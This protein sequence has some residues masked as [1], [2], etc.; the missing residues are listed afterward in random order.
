[1]SAHHKVE[2]PDEQ[3][4]LGS[5]VSKLW[6][7][8]LLIGVVALGAGYFM[9]QGSD[10]TREQFF[11]SYLQNFSYF[12]SLAVGCLF[13]VLI[14][15][16]C[17]AGWS[18]SLR[19]MA[20][21]FSMTLIPLALLMLL[22]IPGIHDLY[23]WSHADHVEGDKILQGKA[24]WLNEGFFKFRLVFY[25][26][27]W[28]G[29]AWFFAR[30]SIRQDQSKD[31]KIT[32]RLEGLAAPAM[33]I[34]A[35]SV[36]MAAFDLL[37]SLYP[38]WYSTIW[39]VYFFA[40]SFLGAVSMMVL[41]FHF[42]QRTGVLQNVVTAEH[43]QDL[44]KLMFAFVVFW[45][46]IGF[47]QFMLIWYGNIPEETMWYKARMIGF[48]E[49]GWADVSALLLVGHFIFPFFFL[50]SRHLKRRGIT[51]IFGAAWLLVMHWIDMHWMVMPQLHPAGPSLGLM[52][53]LCFLGVGGIFLGFGLWQLGRQALIPVGDPRLHESLSFENA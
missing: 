3:L 30:G 1:M 45:A 17:R 51:L 40:G 24:P 15:R 48:G 52:D 33:F 39:G 16:L 41:L 10:E 35:L 37:M 4:R 7:V 23:E 46:Y 19:R 18:V 31:H 14:M 21:I 25:G 47:S 50:M 49:G 8:F 11:R 28:A 26:L 43:F 9:G 13:F 12:L 6:I 42:L 44:G 53:V 36:T 20:E 27:L 2:I 5:G 29:M 38:H 22:I 34:F 32:N